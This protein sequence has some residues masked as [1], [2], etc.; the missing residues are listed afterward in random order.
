MTRCGIVVDDTDE[1][2]LHGVSARWHRP[3]MV[4]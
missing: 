1:H 2:E 4:G 3:L